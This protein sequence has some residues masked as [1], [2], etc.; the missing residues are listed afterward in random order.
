MGE[1]GWGA[2]LESS[3][4]CRCGPG[5]CVQPA[6]AV[7]MGGGCGYSGDTSSWCLDGAQAPPFP[8]VEMEPRSLSH[9]KHLK[10]SGK[11]LWARSP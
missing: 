4:L 8:T 6:P 5:R 1:V 3:L 9:R 11:A 2:F 7:D 10:V